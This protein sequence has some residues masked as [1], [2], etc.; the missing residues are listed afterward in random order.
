MRL[1]RLAT[2]GW[3]VVF[4]A[5][6][7]WMA[8]RRQVRPPDA[9]VFDHALH[10]DE[11]DGC[12]DCHQGV[13]TSTALE[14]GLRPEEEKACGAC[15]DADERQDCGMC[16]TDVSHVKRR[17]ASGER[18]QTLAAPRSLGFSHAAH[19]TRTAGQCQACH[20]DVAQQSSMPLPAITMET[21]TEG[22]HV[23]A[24]DYAEARCTHCHTTLQEMPIAAVA[25]YRHGSDWMRQH[26]ALAR[27]QGAHCDQCHQQ[28]T[29]VGCH[30]RVTLASVA[31]LFPEELRSRQ[32]HRGDYATSHAVD[33][34]LRPASC[35]RCH[36]N[37]ASDC[38][39]CHAAAGVAAF[40]DPTR[41]PHPPE[42]VFPGGAFHGTEAR[43]NVVRCAA[44]HDR[45]GVSDCVSCHAV[46]GI[47][48]NPHPVGWSK[49]HELDG[50][51]QGRRA[52]CGACHP[53]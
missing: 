43:V 51:E 25:E 15:H 36:T 31:D 27:S 39:S 2:L 30:S 46:G 32:L 47:G 41:S 52:V 38:A 24:Q 40:G 16:H 14:V 19:L 3:P 35:V 17:R 8:G 5:C 1:G 18:E 21:C 12:S 42:Y 44:C 50:S 34:R 7:W 26:G 53:G 22:C 28:S 4:G 33:A 6:A 23:H 11:W 9:I 20:G 48:G 49:R 45:G 10:A 29:C 37:P 13:A